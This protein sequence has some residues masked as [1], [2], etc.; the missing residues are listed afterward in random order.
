[1]KLKCKMLKFKVLMLALILGFGLSGQIL[2]QQRT[3]E[4]TVTD[5]QGSP[6]PGVTVVV[7]GTAQGTVTNAD[8]NYTLTDISGDVTLVFSFVGMKT[9]EI[10]IGN[11]TTINLI[12]D[13]DVIG[14]DE[15][16]AV[17]Y[18]TVK[19]S[20]L[21]GSVERIKSE[22]LE[23]KSITNLI[24]GLAGTVAGF[25]SEQ[26]TSASGGGSMLIRGTT[27]LAANNTPLVVLDGVIYSGNIADIN[28]NDI[29]NIDILKD[30]SSSAIFGARASAGIISITTKKGQ[31]SKP[32]INISSKIGFVNLTKEM[33]P[34]GIP[35]TK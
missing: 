4:G 34:F 26:G 33:K 23:K 22:D 31:I 35:S 5:N 10:N 21:T 8:G 3:I 14:L 1:M 13:Q 6:L 7:K 19:K 16:I 9:K 18:G 29:E 15:V 11:Q 17:G 24:E 20:D 32:I 30:A 25:Y 28:P 27:S 12:L 2:T